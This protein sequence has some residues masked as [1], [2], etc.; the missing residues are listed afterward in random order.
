LVDKVASVAIV[1]DDAGVLD[2]LRFLLEVAGHN[3]A[4]YRSAEAFLASGDRVADCLIV[5]HHMP[6]MT[7]LELVAQLNNYVRTPNIMLI[8]GSS[9][10]A[11]RE[12]AADLG[13]AKVVEKPLC[14]DDLLDFVNASIGRP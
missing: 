12:R 3:V 11:I 2:S 10:P 1:D 8:T 13:V 7:G 4:A 5:D 14:G 6:H 9:T